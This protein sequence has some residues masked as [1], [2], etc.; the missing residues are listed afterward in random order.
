MDL[1]IIPDGVPDIVNLSENHKCCFCGHLIR[2]R[3]QMW[4]YPDNKYMCIFC[5]TLIDQ[6]N[7]K[8]NIYSTYN[9]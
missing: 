5:K 1:A 8:G 3:K 9:A 6:E 7:A 2:R 4:K